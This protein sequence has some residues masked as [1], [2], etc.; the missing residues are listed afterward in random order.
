MSLFFLD[1]D[2]LTLFERAHPVVCARVSARVNPAILATPP[3]R[4][5]GMM[6]D[7]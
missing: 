1:T 2:I 3:Y 5:R 7:E 4:A 6:K